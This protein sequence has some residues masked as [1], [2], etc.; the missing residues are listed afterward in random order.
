MISL[1]F[2]RTPGLRQTVSIHVN[3]EEVLEIYAGPGVY[4]DNRPDLKCSTGADCR[5]GKIGLMYFSGC[6]KILYKYV[7][8]ECN[9]LSSHLLGQQHLNQ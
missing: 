7:V 1:L 9:F 2:F 5:K 3:V 6:N 4:L 8:V